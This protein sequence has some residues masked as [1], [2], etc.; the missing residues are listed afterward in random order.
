METNKQKIKTDKQ[1]GRVHRGG[2][3]LESWVCE[4]K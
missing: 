2:A 3:I 4:D 1:A